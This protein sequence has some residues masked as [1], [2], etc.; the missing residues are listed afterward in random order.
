MIVVRKV[1]WHG[2]N[3]L[4][5]AQTIVG[6]II[7]AACMQIFG[8]CRLV[9]VV[10][11]R[12]KFRCHSQFAGAAFFSFRTLQWCTRIARSEPDYAGF[13]G[14]TRTLKCAQSD[15]RCESRSTTRR[16]VMLL[17]PPG[18]WTRSWLKPPPRELTEL[19]TL[20]L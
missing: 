14:R 15:R 4:K 20:A 11:S 2:E 18:V 8:Q 17:R 1:R 6:G 16:R 13:V 19:E 3:P 9:A 10:V 5:I 12:L 7:G